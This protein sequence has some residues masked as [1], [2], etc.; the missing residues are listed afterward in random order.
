MGFDAATTREIA[1]SAG[2]T[3]PALRY[4]FDDKLGLFRSCVELVSTRIAR[5]L[6]PLIEDAEHLV[7]QDAHTDELIASY[8]RLQD[9]LIDSFFDL[10]EGHCV[11]RLIFGQASPKAEEASAPFYEGICQPLFLAKAGIMSRIT[12]RPPNDPDTQINVFAVSGIFMNFNLSHQRV[13]K[14][15]GWEV[16]DSANVDALKLILREKALIVLEGMA[17][18]NGTWRSSELA[19]RNSV[20]IIDK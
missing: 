2:V 18:A 11:R 16:G 1:R 6:N 20:S 13:I 3:T 10:N 15:L 14:M 8:C 9:G 7:R 12:G 4:Y 5:R 19:G 17:R